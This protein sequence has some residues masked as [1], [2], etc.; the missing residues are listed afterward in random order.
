M[1]TE[2]IY[3]NVLRIQ[4]CRLIMLS[5]N[6]ATDTK[7][8]CKLYILSHIKLP[9]IIVKNLAKR[10]N[11][12]ISSLLARHFSSFRKFNGIYIFEPD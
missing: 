10:V 11:I 5:I 9:C 7:S 12:F 1:F 3:T 6:F 2:N 8:F 4:Q